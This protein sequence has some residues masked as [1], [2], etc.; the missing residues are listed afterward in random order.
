MFAEFKHTLRRMRGQMIG[1]GI[2][3]ALY[4]LMMVAMYASVAGMKDIAEL[5]KSYPAEMKAFFKGMTALNTPSGYLDSY[6]FSMMPLIVGIFAVSAGAGLLAGDEEKGTLD[7]AL[8]HPISRTAFFCGRLLGFVAATAAMLLVGWLAWLAPIGSQGLGLSPLQLLQPYLPLFAELMLFG[9]LALLLSMLLPASRTASMLS[10]ALLAG[11][12][13]ILGL[14]NLNADL[15]P[16][17]K[18]TPLYY[19]QGGS[20]VDGLNWA[21]LGGLLGAS[22]LL[23]VPAWALFRRRDIRVSGERS[24][25]LPARRR[26]QVTAPTVE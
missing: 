4:G 23:A 26:Q 5:I 15:Q 12:F 6:Y 3:L 10:G 11:S 20:A 21:W 16:F 1:W 17:V 9:A 22:A 18:L 8:A 24:W 7:L 14:A 25:G 2:G 13:L 19:Y